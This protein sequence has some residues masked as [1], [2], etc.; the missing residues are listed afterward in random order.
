MMSFL[1]RPDVQRLGEVLEFTESSELGVAADVLA[2]STTMNGYRVLT[3]WHVHNCFKTALKSP[4]TLMKLIVRHNSKSSVAI[5]WVIAS[6]NHIQ[7]F[8]ILY[9]E[10]TSSHNWIQ[11]CLMV[12]ILQTCQQLEFHT[13]TH[14]YS[15][16]TTGPHTE[17]I[18]TVCQQCPS[19][20]HHSY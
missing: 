12:A 1:T 7:F 3:T 13:M 15:T 6:E 19:A 20:V 8:C 2:L 4:S 5:Q 17:C 10:N 18:E 11:K 14:T 16:M 9:N